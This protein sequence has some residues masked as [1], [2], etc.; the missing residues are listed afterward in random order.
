MET[1]SGEI[2]DGQGPD[3]S[4][5][6]PAA[7]LDDGEPADRGGFCEG[8][9][10]GI[11]VGE[12]HFGGDGRQPHVTLR[13]HTRHAA[14]F[15]WIEVHFPGGRLYGPYLHGGRNYLQWMARGTYLRQVLLPILERRLT[16]EVDAHAF[17]RYEAMKARYAEGLRGRATGRP[18]APS[19]STPTT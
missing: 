16:A 7:R 1:K 11:L 10:V 19:L 13:M 14:L 6:E 3:P 9:L 17:E 2:P 18:D 12:G 5:N 8:F 15:R 4:G